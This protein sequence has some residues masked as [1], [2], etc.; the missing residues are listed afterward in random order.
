M[1][2]KSALRKCL[3]HFSLSPKR[4]FSTSKKVN[5]VLNK[6]QIESDLIKK[7]F[8]SND[9]W[10]KFN[11][12]EKERNYDLTMK[13][14]SK[15]NKSKGLFRNPY[16]KDA[17][18][19]KKFSDESLEAAKALTSNLINVKSSYGLRSYVKDL[20]RLSDILCR[21]IDLCEFIRVVHPK[22]SFVNEAENAHQEL[23]EHMNILNTSKPL[24]DNLDKVLHNK[25]IGIRKQLSNE[26]VAVGELLYA[27][28]KKSG[29]DMDSETGEKFV[30]LSSYIAAAGQEFNNNITIPASSSIKIE[31]SEWKESDFKTEHMKKISK[32]F[33]GSLNIPLYGNIPFDLIRSCPN[34]LIRE[35]VWTALHSVPDEQIQLL[36]NLLRCR[37]ILA[38]LMG[39]QSYSEYALADKMARTPENVLSLLQGLIKDLQSDVIK[40]LRNLYK[41]MPNAE[42]NASDEKVVKSIKPWDREYLL[43]K[44]MLSQKSTQSEDIT[45]YFSL[46]TVVS[47][48]SKLFQSI[49]GIELVPQ[50]IDSGEVWSN[51][52]RRFD[53][54]S[55]ND[56]KVGIM[57]LDLLQR[58]GK[59]PHPAHFTV[60]CSRQIDENE[61]NESDKFNLRTYP[62]TKNVETIIY[63]NKIYQL[64]VI[65]LV[66]NYNT[67][68]AGIICLTLD[69][70]A[71]LFHEMGHAMHSMLGRTELHN[72]SGTRCQTD[73]VEL[74]SILHETFARDERV[75]ASFGRHYKTGE[76]VPLEL[77]RKHLAADRILSSTETFGQ[78]KMALLDQLYHGATEININDEKFD[79]I[80][81]YHEL[82]SNLSILADTKSTWPGKFGHLYS[83]GAV[84]YSYLL[85]RAI[86]AKVWN[87]L[88]E[89]DPFSREAG[90]K[91][92][93]EVLR[94]GGSRDPWIC[95]AKVLNIPELA[96][97]DVK[98]MNLI[99]EKSHISR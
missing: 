18:G 29:I 95:L 59:T 83:Y 24:F 61:L 58:S 80:A 11:N 45:E 54:I 77:L 2:H 85:D 66:C 41:F 7:I 49:Y 38:K 21:V 63:D 17:K 99:S 91:F 90:E 13:M 34:S 68:S 92:K 1:G 60:V 82:E 22:K 70:V 27:D 79:A 53:A 72:V 9:E 8:D 55:D 78:A 10:K 39:C 5:E 50:R 26:E 74:P 57:Y 47:G 30:Q 35:K 51:E 89:K 64:P 56:G 96:K 62:S 16:L 69:Q 86:A 36:T 88:F 52:V 37:E 87:A 33:D 93:N 71:T 48:L 40:E 73:F 6:S 67:N 14:F 4:T 25:E 75:L 20:D 94:W 19:L 31:P 76:P 43:T 3:I 23:F 44:Y 81:L 84:Y 46:G 28:F 12:L 15:S 97:G 65:S 98:A 32:G 42:Q